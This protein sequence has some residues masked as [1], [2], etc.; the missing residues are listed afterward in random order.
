MLDVNLWLLLGPA[1]CLGI[2]SGYLSERVGIVNIAINGM[3]TFGAFFFMIFS[4]VFEAAFGRDDF[5]W[6]FLLSMLISVVL[7]IPVGA[8][9]ALATV[10]LKADHTIAGTGI[11]LLASGIGMI[12]AD[13]A[14]T[15]FVGRTALS[16]RYQPVFTIGSSGSSVSVESLICFFIAIIVIVAF[17]V[18][19]N[20]TRL[21]L[22]YRA[23]GENPNAVD[24]Q[25]INVNKYQWSGLLVAAMVAG[26]GGSFFAYSISLSSF[27]GDVD[28]YGFIAVALLILSS[29]KI[30][31]GCIIGLVFALILTITKTASGADEKIYMLRTLPFI[32]SLL[33]MVVA[34][35]FIKGPAYAG[36]HFDKSLR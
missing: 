31:P 13:R 6:T 26:L 24:A 8:L 2:L 16:N 28:G 33:T 17:W 34:G 23:C 19:M 36:K 14:S 12:I 35:R 1:L 3:M 20:Y 25:G 30:L 7:S 10:K 22:R 21:G 4:N 15:F 29:W 32:L 27:T 11:N 18:V 5:N 9:F